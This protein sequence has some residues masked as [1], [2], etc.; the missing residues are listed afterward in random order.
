MM[1]YKTVKIQQ[2][3][4][5]ILETRKPSWRRGKRA[6][7]VRVWRSLAKKWKLIDATS[8]HFVAVKRLLVDGY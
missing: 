8:R 2:E 7:A 6:T 1:Y 4:F 3:L 5:T